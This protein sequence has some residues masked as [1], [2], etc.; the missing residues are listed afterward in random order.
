MSEFPSSQ[1]YNWFKE[2]FG[3]TKLRK[4]DRCVDEYGSLENC[5]KEIM[6]IAFD[7]TESEENPINELF[8]SFVK[9]DEPIPID[10]LF[11]DIIKKAMNNKVVPSSNNR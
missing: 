3:D 10:K 6:S 11:W 1:F 9:G 4:L 2:K 8:W 7:D 5:V